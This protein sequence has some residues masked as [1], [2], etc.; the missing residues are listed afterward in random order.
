MMEE[1]KP[2]ILRGNARV[3]ARERSLKERKT[4]AKSKMG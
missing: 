1:P 2:M 4:K 3:K